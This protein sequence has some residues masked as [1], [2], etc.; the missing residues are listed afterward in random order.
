MSDQEPT[1][2]AERIT[3]GPDGTEIRERWG[4]R[5]DGSYVRRVYRSLTDDERSTL[6]GVPEGEQGV[7]LPPSPARSDQP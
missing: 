4:R 6:L 7:R 1:D 5:P 3:T 2:F